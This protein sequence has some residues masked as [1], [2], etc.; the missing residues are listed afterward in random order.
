MLL[1]SFFDKIS[2]NR[3]RE[4][5]DLFR[6]HGDALSLILSRVTK[7]FTSIL[8][9]KGRHVSFLWL[10]Y[11]VSLSISHGGD[12]GGDKGLKEGLYWALFIL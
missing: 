9:L 6:I 3:Y 10:L 4:R 1:T 7:C 5:H 8:T 2:T 12:Y 11:M